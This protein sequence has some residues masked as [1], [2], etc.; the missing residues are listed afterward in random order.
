MLFFWFKTQ[1]TLW[2]WKLNTI[3]SYKV[4]LLLV[5]NVV[6]VKLAAVMEQDIPTAVEA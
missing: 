5:N 2:G 1:E 3:V 6:P 4:S